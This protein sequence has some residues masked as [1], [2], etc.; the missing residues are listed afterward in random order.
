MGEQESS[1]RDKNYLQ[2]LKPNLRSFNVPN[3]KRMVGV[4]LEIP[5]YPLFYF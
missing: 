1:P 5:A 3:A 4:V 2:G